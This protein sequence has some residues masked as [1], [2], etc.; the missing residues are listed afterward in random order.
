M[1]LKFVAACIALFCAKPF[2][3]DAQGAPNSD[4]IDPAAF[5]QQTVGWDTVD[6]P[7]SQTLTTTAGQTG[8]QS[9]AYRIYLTLGWLC[10][11]QHRFTDAEQYYQSA[12]RFARSAFGER[13]DPVVKALYGIGATRLDQGRIREADASFHQA[14]SILESGNNANPLDIAAVLNNLAAVQQMSGNFSKAAALMRKVVHIVETDPAADAV[15]LGSALSNLATMLRHVGNRPE[16]VTA[17]E[18][19]GSILECCTNTKPFTSNLVIRAL[20]RLDEG[21]L[22]GGENMLLRALSTTEGPSIQG[23]PAQAVILTH[24]GVFYARNGRQREAEPYF[25]RAL[26][27]NRRLLA[28]DHPGLLESMGAYA[29][30]LRATRRK[31]EAKKLEA[32]IDEHRK[33]YHADNPALA[34]VID[35]HS[36]MKQRG[37]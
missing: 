3:S 30:L 13:T 35:V 9:A 12:Y 14:L 20:L 37:H 26:E 27:I 11:I 32:Y 18:R 17:A 10:E 23:S 8:Q 4:C 22:A 29:A 31:S 28:P 6:S 19:A 15:E 25:Q 34:N 2:P 5:R 33:K 36:L 24:L 7:R 1:S 21:D 16:A